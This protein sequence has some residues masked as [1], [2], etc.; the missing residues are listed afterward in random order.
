LARNAALRPGRKTLETANHP[1]VDRS[2]FVM[3]SSFLE[4]ARV[5]ASAALAQLEELTSEVISAQ[6]KQKTS[7][8]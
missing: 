8:R 3:D 4:K 5:A 2:A 1:F 6:G 7:G